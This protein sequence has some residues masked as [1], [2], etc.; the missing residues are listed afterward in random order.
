MSSFDCIQPPDPE[1]RFRLTGKLGK[2]AEQEIFIGTSSWKYPGWL[3]SIYTQ[4]R[5]QT[6]SKHSKKKFE[7]SCI[8]EYGEV[9]PIV[10]GDFA[11]Y[12]FPDE[13]FWRK[14]FTTAP[15]SLRWAFKVPEEITVRRWP[16]HARY[17]PRASVENENFLNAALF[18]NA[19]LNALAPYHDRI[20]A[21][22]FEFG[23]M[24]RTSIPG[25]D[26][27]LSQLDPFL[28]VLPEGWRY[29]VEIRND[30]F[31]EQ[32]YL[33]CLKSHNVAHVLNSW[34][35]MPGLSKQLAMNGI[36]TADFS[37]VRALLRPG[38]SYEQAVKLF[39]PYQSV[40]DE[41][42]H[43]RES[44]KEVIARA[45][46]ERQPSFIFVNNRLEGYAPGTIDA[47]ADDDF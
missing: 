40:Q 32:E 22:I 35:H 24:S 12:Q 46:R 1:L 13:E 25:L 11:F 3:G 26:A 34:T 27:F 42:P 6:R 14:L 23:S 31:L 38:R 37:L 16:A 39:A 8:A 29:A 15:P 10:C 28:R 36:F 45:Q 18:K 47:V 2:L 33:A 7:A 41:Y 5:Y 43:A 44:M 9:F 20:S 21:L 4:D 30:K 17:G 19:F